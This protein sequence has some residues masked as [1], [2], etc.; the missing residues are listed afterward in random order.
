[1]KLQWFERAPPERLAAVR[2]AVGLYLIDQLTRFEGAFTAIARTHPSQWRPVGPLKLWPGP[3]DPA[4]FDR[5][6]EAHVVLAWL[7]VLGFAHRFVT[8]L[9]ALSSLHFFAYRTAWGGALHS[10]N[11]VVFHLFCLALGPATAAWSVDAWMQR[12]WPGR[13]RWLRW[14]ELPRDDWGYGWCLK[15][16][17]GVTTITYLLAGVAKLIGGDGLGWASGKMLL[18][19]IGN[20]ALFKELVS[21]GGATPMVTEV[22]RNSA[23]LVVPATLTLVVEVGAP[24]A[25]LDKRL[26]WLWSL[27]A[28]GMH[29]GILMIMGINFPYPVTGVAF[30]SFFPLER[31]VRVLTAPFRWLWEATLGARLRRLGL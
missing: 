15:L 9:Y 16:M 4:L 7:F 19:Q 23:W 13:F 2:I 24:L 17:C 8:P 12:T 30:L 28:L 27:G 11:L 20:D 25:L 5:W 14:P 18:D 26:G 29:H 21:S 22:Y 10:D 6:H 1:L 3:I 31:W